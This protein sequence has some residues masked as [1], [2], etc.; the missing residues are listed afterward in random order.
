MV[1]T[2]RVDA[3]VRLFRH[4]A[5]VLV[6]SLFWDEAAQAMRWTDITLGLL[7]SGRLD[8][9]EDGRRDTAWTVPPPL[10]SFQPAVAGG[11]VAGLGARVAR[12][13]GS[14]RVTATLAEIRH[15]GGADLRLNEGKCDPF[16]AFVVGSMNL[17][18]D[19]PLGRIYRVRDGG[20]V[21]VL[22]DGVTVANGFEWSD[23]GRTFFYTDTAAKTVYAADYDPVGPLGRSHPLLVGHASDG[24][25]LDTDGCF[26][27]GVYGAGQVL[28]WTPD[29]EVAEV[30][31]VPAPNV[32]SVAFGGPDLATLFIG[33]A[34]ENLTERRL[35][36]YPLSGSVFA[37]ETGARGRP[38]E[39]FGGP[40]RSIDT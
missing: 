36:E 8:D 31:D 35:E 37:V 12:L 19:R 23:D 26:W 13:D 29:G 25:A 39:R 16:G 10:A 32:T 11:F 5:S 9:P 21:E 4:E 28:K 6:E 1:V 2:E 40:S 3:P 7:H 27:N 18:D 14:G 30:V 34:R 24:L 17:T 15:H 22:V 38:V 33:T 20:E